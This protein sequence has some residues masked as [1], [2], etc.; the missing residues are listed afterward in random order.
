MAV[1]VARSH[2]N[3]VIKYENQVSLYI[4]VWRCGFSSAKFAHKKSKP[5][6]LLS[7]VNHELFKYNSVITLFICVFIR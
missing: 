4:S 1:Y 6:M 2:A 3:R 5:V 7:Q